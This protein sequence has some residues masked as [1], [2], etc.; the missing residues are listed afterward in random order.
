MYSEKP[1]VFKGYSF[2]Y[3]SE[4][5]N[6]KN[7]INLAE[8]QYY[9]LEQ[10]NYLHSSSLCKQTQT[11]LLKL[12]ITINFGLIRD[13]TN[14]L[15]TS[16]ER[17]KQYESHNHGLINPNLPRSLIYM[18]CRRNF[19]CWE[20]M[21]KDILAKQVCKLINIHFILPIDISKISLKIEFEI[22]EKNFL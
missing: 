5:S 1:V 3:L 7:K 2:S 12:T 9:I 15:L 6:F 10:P 20:K 8:K 17:N 18:I 22:Q 21:N 13:S 11:D 14:Q 16:F 19:V 4:T